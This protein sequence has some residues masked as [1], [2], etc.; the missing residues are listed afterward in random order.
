MT[1]QNISN[2]LIII[3]LVIIILYAIYSCNK[4]EKD[5]EFETINICDY[6]IDESELYNKTGELDT[7]QLE[8]IINSVCNEYFEENKETICKE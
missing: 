8:N 3:G 7:K 1:K 4:I 6:E 5:N 2:I